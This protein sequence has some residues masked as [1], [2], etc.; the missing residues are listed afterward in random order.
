MPAAN[1]FV[2]SIWAAIIVPS[3]DRKK[4]SLAS[5]RHRG[6]PPPSREM[7]NSPGRT[8]NGRTYTSD[9]PD[10]FDLYAIHR[11]SGEKRPAPSLCRVFRNTVGL[12]S[13]VVFSVQRSLFELESSV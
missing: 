9:R 12:R 4:I 8:G 2:V 1:P 5:P 3:S 10:A 7:A 11:S 6:A 13:A